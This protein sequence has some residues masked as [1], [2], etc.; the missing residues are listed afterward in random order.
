MIMSFSETPQQDN[1]P[2]QLPAVIPQPVE[3]EATEIIFRAAPIAHLKKSEAK[4]RLINMLRYRRPRDSRSWAEFVRKFL[5]DLPGIWAD[6]KCNLFV[7]IGEAPDVLWSSH[8]DSVHR[9]GGMQD[10]VINGQWIELPEKSDS[11]CLGADDAAGMWIMTE[12]IQAGVPGLYVFHYGEE[13]G[14]IGSDY[15]ATKNKA[16][17]DGIK[18]A[19][20]F[21]RRGY[22]DVITFQMGS[23][24]CSNEFAESLA[25]Q[26]PFGFKPCPDGIYTD[27]ASY[28]DIVPE[29]TN[30]SVGYFNEHTSCECLNL[31]HVLELRDAMVNIDTSKLVIKRDPSK[32]SGWGKYGRYC[33]S[34]EDEDW[35]HNY[36]GSNYGTGYTVSEKQDEQKSNP[37]GTAVSVYNPYD[38]DPDVDRDPRSIQELCQ[39]FPDQLADVL[40]G[41]GLTVTDL[42]A[43]IKDRV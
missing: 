39:R 15:I 35:W 23:R 28:M 37:S 14:C 9:Q 31:V 36:G 19:I 38:L 11:N 30:L 13:S 26:L 41:Y 6:K 8:T 32:R 21:D 29:C 10:V 22:Y 5:C 12:M 20:A 27:T 17:L 42:W 18:M 3:E 2:V 24:C 34:W 25:L 7:Q 40:E 1:L 4:N 33:E 16:V 43:E